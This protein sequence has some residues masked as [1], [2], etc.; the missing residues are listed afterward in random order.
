MAEMAFAILEQE[1]TELV[2]KLQNSL[3]RDT[4]P[5]HI[6][7][8]LYSTNILSR[9]ENTR[10]DIIKKFLN[11]KKMTETKHFDDIRL[12]FRKWLSEGFVGVLGA[13]GSNLVFDFL[14]IYT[15][16]RKMSVNVCLTLFHLLRPLLREAKG[17]KKIQNVFLEGPKVLLIRDLRRVLKYFSS[18]K[19]EADYDG[20][21]EAPDVPKLEITPPSARAEK[22]AK[23][24]R[25]KAMQ[26]MN[27]IRVK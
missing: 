15:F 8:T 27:Y 19:G 6:D 16:D 9:D 7:P 17:F 4:N 14:F 21:P 1:E 2:A 20:I 5:D 13:N 22:R 26:D 12:F 11:K 25:V 23:D 18:N 24:R 10:S 3:E